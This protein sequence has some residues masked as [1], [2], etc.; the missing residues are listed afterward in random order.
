MRLAPAYE[1]CARVPGRVGKIKD[2]RS[3][4]TRPI[5]CSPVFDCNIGGAQKTM[6]DL[7]LSSPL[8]TPAVCSLVVIVPTQRDLASLRRSQRESVQKNLLAIT[9]AANITSVPIFVFSFSSKPKTHAFAREFRLT[10]HSEFLGE[11]HAFPWQSSSFKDAVAAKGRYAIVL[12]GFWLEHQVIATA[13][14]AL[15]DSYDVYVAIDA[16]PARMRSAAP[17]SQDRL[18]QAGATPVATSQV[19]HE[20]SLELSDVSGR[21]RLRP[22]LLSQSDEDGE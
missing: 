13:L 1:N 4:S 15:A 22:F 12:A 10:K 7:T 19:I 8:I 17:L 16:S 18:I 9:S 2:H 6:N 11:D 3:Y 21:A 20:W 5:I 14:H